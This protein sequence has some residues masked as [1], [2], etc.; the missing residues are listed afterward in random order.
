ME[1]KALSPQRSSFQSDRGVRCSRY[2][3][4][5]RIATSHASAAAW[6][7]CR[8]LLRRH[9]SIIIKTIIE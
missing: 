4:V 5:A 9:F 1:D 7:I 8:F 3:G 6:V 2:V